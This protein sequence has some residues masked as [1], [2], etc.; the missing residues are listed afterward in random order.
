MV[1]NRKRKWAAILDLF[2]QGHGHGRA[3][4]QRRSSVQ[5]GIAV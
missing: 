4:I 5:V 3:N 2:L 1:A